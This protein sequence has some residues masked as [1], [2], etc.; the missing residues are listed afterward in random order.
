MCTD[1]LAL[2]VGGAPDNALSLYGFFWLEQSCLAFEND[3]LALFKLL[4]VVISFDPL[5][6][7][8]G[9]QHKQHCLKDHHKR[10]TLVQII[11]RSQFFIIGP[12]SVIKQTQHW[13]R[14]TKY[15]QQDIRTYVKGATGGSC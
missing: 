4:V 15:C 3:A 13:A 5:S 2:F 6:Q 8:D 1:G 12:I 14:N 10:K 7:H 11:P 9:H